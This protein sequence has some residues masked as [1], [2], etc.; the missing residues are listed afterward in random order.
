[1]FLKKSCIH[2]NKSY[3]NEETQYFCMVYV[4]S[5]LYSHIYLHTKHFR[6][7]PFLTWVQLSWFDL[8]LLDISL[9]TSPDG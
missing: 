8:K 7:W 4:L 5:S 3:S 6:C 2:L 9:I 1:M